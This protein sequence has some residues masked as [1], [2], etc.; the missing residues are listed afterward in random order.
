MKEQRFTEKM[1]KTWYA[2]TIK[3]KIFA[4]IGAVVL[5]LILSI[6]LNVWVAKFSLI[7]FIGILSDN[8]KSS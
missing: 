2:M 6:V 1:K 8:T 7:D 4:F 3:R 5:T